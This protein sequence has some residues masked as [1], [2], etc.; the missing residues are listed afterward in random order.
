MP[1]SHVRLTVASFV[2]AVFLGTTAQAAMIG[3]NFEGSSSNGKSVGPTKVAGVEPQSHWNDLTSG[4]SQLAS[5]VDDS[6]NTI[7]GLVV[8]PNNGD[9]EFN[10]YVF[11]DPP[12]DG[13]S[14]LMR[15]YMDNFSGSPVSVVVTG[16][17]A[18]FTTHGYDVIVYFDGDNPSSDWLT[19]YAI[20][21]GGAPFATIY[22][23]DD[24]DTSAWDGQF[25]EASGATADSA[26]VGNYVRFTGLTSGD[27]TLTAMPQTGDGPINGIQIVAVPE[28]AA[29]AL[30]GLGLAATLA[31]RRQ[32]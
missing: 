1:S 30:L 14:Y 7:A 8:N 6:G 22:G 2:C 11:V 12:F 28:P 26:T 23:K 9:E 16:L 32:T 20:A 4:F 3:I 17:G 10:S 25:H 21:V 29:L 15:G 19:A 27:F 5:V 24:Q 13:D 18:P 31:R